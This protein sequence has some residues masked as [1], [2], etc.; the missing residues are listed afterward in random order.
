[1]R[2]CTLT[3]TVK[4]G[5]ETVEAKGGNERRAK[6]VRLA[7]SR[8]TKALKA[9]RVIG[10]LANRSQYEYS[11]VDVKKIIAALSAETEALRNR[12]SDADRK[13]RFE[14]KL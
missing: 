9:I 2:R 12:L 3:E 10:N 8:M 5:S 6:F 11:D 1:V 14:F 7:E 13:K 4:E